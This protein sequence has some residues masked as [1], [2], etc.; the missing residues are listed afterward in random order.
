ML[1]R[2]GQ[3]LGRDQVRLFCYLTTIVAFSPNHHYCFV[4]EPFH[5]GKR[6]MTLDE[7][8][9]IQRYLELFT[10]LLHTVFVM[11]STAIR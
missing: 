9:R 8:V 4:L 11:V 5:I 1:G 3:K 2:A 6:S 10:Q 7:H